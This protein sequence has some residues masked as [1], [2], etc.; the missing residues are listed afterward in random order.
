M[1]ARDQWTQ[2]LDTLPCFT[3]G[4]AAMF[5]AWEGMDL[6]E[7]RAL[8]GNALLSSR[9]PWL[10]ERLRAALASVLEGAVTYDDACALPGFRIQTSTRG[11]HLPVLAI[12]SDLSHVLVHPGATPSARPISFAL[13]VTPLQADRALSFWD[14]RHAE[15]VGLDSEETARALER[16]HQVQVD[17]VPGGLVVFESD[18]FHQFAPLREAATRGAR[19]IM[20]GHAVLI[21][22]GWRVFG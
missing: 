9:F 11:A 16:A 10:Y 3:L 6:Y 14:M 15:I 17:L 12:R 4:A 18:H 22:G 21:D 13:C 7:S 1:A 20:G 2:R 8:S 19:I 5:D